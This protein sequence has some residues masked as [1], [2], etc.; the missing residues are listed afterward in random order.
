LRSVGFAENAQLPLGAYSEFRGVPVDA[1]AVLISFAITADANLDR[2][3]NDDDVTVVGATYAPGVP[4]ANWAAGDFDYNGFVDDDD[5]TLLGALYDPT[6]RP[7]AAPPLARPTATTAGRSDM[8]GV[9]ET[10]GQDHVRGRE[11]RAQQQETRS[12]QAQQRAISGGQVSGEWSKVDYELVSLLA[13]SIANE[14]ERGDGLAPSNQRADQG[15]HSQAN[16]F[17]MNWR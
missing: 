14:S 7:Q 1:T 6:V 8:S 3:V 4:N 9:L 10:F 11:T 12:Q 15:S 16:E 5:V 13:E 2:A 17:W